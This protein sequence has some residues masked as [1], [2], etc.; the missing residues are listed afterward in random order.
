MA[1]AQAGVDVTAAFLYLAFGSPDH[2]HTTAEALKAA[3]VTYIVFLNHS[4]RQGSDLRALQPTN[5][6]T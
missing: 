3:G 1:V 5:W 2:I 4:T 6:G